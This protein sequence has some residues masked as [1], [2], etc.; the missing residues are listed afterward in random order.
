VVKIGYLEK[1]EVLQL[2]ECP[3]K[4]YALHYE[5]DASQRVV[6]LTRGHPALVQLLCYEI[7]TLKNT[8]GATERRLACLADVETA[9]PRALESGNLFFAE[10]EQNQVDE[11]GLTLLRFMAAHGE[12]AV[13][14]LDAL[15][16]QL[17]AEHPD[18]L[19]QTMALLLQRDLIEATDGGYRFQVE[20]VRRWFEQT[21]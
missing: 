11:A 6:D 5:P 3:V 2:V 17:R 12:G 20:L 18:D 15:A 7:V 19:S 4:G 14:N 10:I 16:R 8:H 9:V 21:R 13:L 1:D